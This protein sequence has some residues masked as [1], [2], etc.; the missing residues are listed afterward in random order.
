M[1]SGGSIS[2]QDAQLMTPQE[3]QTTVKVINKYNKEKAGKSGEGF[4]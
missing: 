1:Y 2:W 3:R 4:M